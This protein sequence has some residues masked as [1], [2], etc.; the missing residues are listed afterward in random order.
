M[1]RHFSAPDKLIL[2]TV[3]HELLAMVGEASEEKKIGPK[4]YS[5]LLTVPFSLHVAQNWK[6]PLKTNST[7]KKQ[8][9]K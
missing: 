6:S 4:L 1:C 7:L 8:N 2:G 9:K 3:F 5:S